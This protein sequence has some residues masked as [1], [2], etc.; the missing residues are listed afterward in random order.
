MI[1]GG[2]KILVTSLVLILAPLGIMT[3]SGAY[4]TAFDM[5]KTIRHDELIKKGYGEPYSK[6]FTMFSDSKYS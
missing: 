6:F 5:M 3:I 4:Y 1:P 2:E